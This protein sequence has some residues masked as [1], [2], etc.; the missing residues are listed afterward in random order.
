MSLRSE[1]VT[2]LIDGECPL[3]RREGAWL[4]R[5][6][7][8]RGNLVLE[9]ISGPGFDPDRYGRSMDELMGTMHAALPGGRLVTG[10][11]AFR[12]AYR[13]VGLG[14]VLAPTGWPVLRPIFDRLY[15]VFARHRLRLTRR[16]GACGERCATPSAG[17]R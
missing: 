17:V 14:W 6:D 9:D 1:R 8:G 12:R 16:S 3:C 11:E 5:L 15:G 10:M 4:S 7:R 13:S 2:L